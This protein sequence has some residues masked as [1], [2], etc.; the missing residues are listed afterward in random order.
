MKHLSHHA[1]T[2]DSGRSGLTAAFKWKWKISATVK[3]QMISTWP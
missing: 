3:G 2:I 1:R